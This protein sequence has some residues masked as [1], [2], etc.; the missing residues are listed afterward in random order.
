MAIFIASIGHSSVNE[1]HVICLAVCRHSLVNEVHVVCLAVCRHSWSMKFTWYALQSED[2]LVNFYIT[3]YIYIYV[4][5]LHGSQWFRL[6]N[7][8][9]L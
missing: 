3:V 7:H 9:L 2:T 4:E 6:N 5:I 8:L 1:V